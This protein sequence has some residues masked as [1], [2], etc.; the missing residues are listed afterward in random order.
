M[1]HGILGQEGRVVEFLNPFDAFGAGDLD[2][3]EPVGLPLG[4]PSGP[5]GRSFGP[6]V[7]I[8]I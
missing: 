8:H 2:P 3:F 1:G 7:T 4:L 6:K 5:T